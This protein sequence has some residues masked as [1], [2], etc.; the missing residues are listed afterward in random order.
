MNDE[1]LT[2][3]TRII[4]NGE[5]AEL[6][7]VPLVDTVIHLAA[8]VHVMHERSADP[9]AEFRTANVGMTR[10][11]AQWAA[12]R[13]V[14][15][16]IFISSVKV[17]GESTPSGQVFSADDTPSPEDPYA[18]SKMEAE[19]ALS[20]ACV[21]SS[22]E[23]VIIRPPLVYGPGVQGNFRSLVRWI[24]RGIPLPLGAI[25]NRRSLLALDN[26]TD[27]IAICL[28]HPAA[29][30]QVFLAADG[31]DVS[32]TVLL[33]KIAAAYGKPSRLIPVSHFW[34]RQAGA[35]LG[36]KAAVERLLGSL[37]VDTTKTRD[38]LGWTPSISM[39]EQLRKM[40]RNDART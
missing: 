14:K 17:N 31:E 27:L 34:L 28:I 22:M 18:V 7:A 29:A 6:M 5:N 30:N 24:K 37:V 1:L 23:F 20:A 2:G 33:H 13:G 32:T 26:L 40:V 3:V 8:R 10:N 9:L 38:L 39:D 35:L 11:L 19:H 12:T 36:K 4:W 16:F 21:N 15:R 25:S